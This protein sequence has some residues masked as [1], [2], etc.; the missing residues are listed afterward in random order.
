MA[1][2]ERRSAASTLAV[3]DWTDALDLVEAA[4][5]GA[6]QGLG[7][8]GAGGVDAGVE[9]GGELFEAGLRDARAGGGRA[10]LD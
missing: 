1:W 4:L 9:L 5:G 10:L 8:L 2:W 7:H 6:F 3:R